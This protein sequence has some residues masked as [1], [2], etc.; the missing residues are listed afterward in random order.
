M[1]WGGREDCR[2]SAQFSDQRRPAASWR[3]A[4]GP[5]GPCGRASSGPIPPSGGRPKEYKLHPPPKP[6]PGPPRPAKQPVRP[7]ANPSMPP[8]PDEPLGRQGTGTLSVHALG[9][10]ARLTCTVCALYRPPH[11]IMW[12][13]R[14][15]DH[16]PRGP[17]EKTAWSGTWRRLQIEATAIIN[18]KRRAGWLDVVLGPINGR[19]F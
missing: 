3:H 19:G 15:K 16:L 12:E 6:L 9:P 4:I 7:L 11:L 18:L 14:L 10:L 2:G 5:A 8:L 13:S 1:T 17:L